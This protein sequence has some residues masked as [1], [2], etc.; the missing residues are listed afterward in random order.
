MY[1]SFLA[2]RFFISSCEIFKVDIATLK[3]Q[4]LKDYEDKLDAITCAYTMWYCQNHESKFYQIDG[5]DT[6][7]TPISKWKVYILR[8]ADDT[9]Y[10]G[11][12]TDL[13]KR[14]HEH[15]NSK[16]GAKY[17]KVRRPVELV[18]WQNADDR[19]DASKKEY[20]IKQLSRKEKL[21]LIK[22]DNKF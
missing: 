10:T 4:K 12:T 9:L 7:L 11:I 13:R 19:V 15:N 14:V 21:K 18:Y 1:C 5:I 22:L 2:F 8:C 3:G 6:F 17:T 16:L 20:A